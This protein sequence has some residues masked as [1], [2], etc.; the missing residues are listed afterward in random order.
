MHSKDIRHIDGKTEAA[1]VNEKIHPG[2]G[3]HSAPDEMDSKCARRG[4]ATAVRR[5]AR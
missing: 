3:N 1:S 2:T 4:N 5:P